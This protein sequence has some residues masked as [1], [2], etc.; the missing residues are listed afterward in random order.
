MARMVAP[1]SMDNHNQELVQD[2]LSSSSGSCEQ[3]P[4]EGIL[5]VSAPATAEAHQ[6]LF[7]PPASVASHASGPVLPESSVTDFLASPI[8]QPHNDNSS[9]REVNHLMGTNQ[10]ENP[11]DLVLEPHQSSPEFPLGISGGSQSLTGARI[12]LDICCGV[13]SPLS[14]AVH[15]LKGDV[16]RFDILVHAT[17]DLLNLTSYERL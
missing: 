2:I 3:K 5:P 6:Q 13:N 10:N 1:D 16:M 17:D 4:V 11:H 7:H 14:N 12:F 15:Q 8:D 9:S